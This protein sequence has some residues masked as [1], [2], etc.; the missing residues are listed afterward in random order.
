MKLTLDDIEEKDDVLIVKIPNTKTHVIRKFSVC[1]YG[2]YDTR[3]TDLNK[4]Y[5]LLR[6]DNTISPLFH[7]IQGWQM[8]ETKRRSKYLG[9]NTWAFRILKCTPV[10]VFVDLQLQCWRTLDPISPTF[11]DTVGGS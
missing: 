3:Y 8:Y 10:I 4:R 11:R 9:Q 7:S 5:Q 1:N 2:D 6:P